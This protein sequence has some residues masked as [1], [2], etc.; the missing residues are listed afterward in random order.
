VTTGRLCRPSWNV[1]LSKRRPGG[2]ERAEGSPEAI[3]R[4]R[5][6]PSEAAQ[7]RRR[8]WVGE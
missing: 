4:R 5:V 1:I 7:R 6:I 3:A 2:P 8:I